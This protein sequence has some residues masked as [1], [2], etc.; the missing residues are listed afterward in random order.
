MRSN[1]QIHAGMEF[2]SRQKVQE[3]SKLA[4]ARTETSKTAEASAPNQHLKLSTK[5]LGHLRSA[6]G[7]V[8]K[9]KQDHIG[10]GKIVVAVL[11]VLI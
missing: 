7:N 1:P 4:L 3:R 10:G 8:R 2:S 6:R 5:C 11:A 9:I